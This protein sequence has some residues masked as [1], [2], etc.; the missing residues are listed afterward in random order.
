MAPS[1]A[2]MSG[3]SRQV[4]R[5]GGGKRPGLSIE[6]SGVV[7]AHDRLRDYC[8]SPTDAVIL[9][10]WPVQLSPPDYVSFPPLS[11]HHPTLRRSGEGYLYRSTERCSYP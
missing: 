8:V 1:A 7:V 11:W 6:E 9:A 4:W 5:R 10:A 2:L 3:V